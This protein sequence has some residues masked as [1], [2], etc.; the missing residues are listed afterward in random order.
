MQVVVEIVVRRSRAVVPGADGYPVRER[1]AGRRR[2][3][4]DWSP[5]HH[6][7]HLEAQARA[8]WPTGSSVSTGGVVDGGRHAEH[9][10]QSRRRPAGRGTAQRWASWRRGPPAA[11][12]ARGRAATARPA[13]SGSPASTQT[14]RLAVLF[15]ICR[16]SGPTWSKADLEGVVARRVQ[17]TVGAARTDPRPAGRGRSPRSARIEREGGR[18]GANGARSARRRRR[19]GSGGDLRAVRPARR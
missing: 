11:D 12:P 10:A 13:R 7:G 2:P 4:P 15:I 8:Q 5:D 17:Q 6:Q 14:C 16:P 18:I 3:A 1:H 19:C 9:R